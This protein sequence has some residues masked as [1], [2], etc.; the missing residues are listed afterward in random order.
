MKIKTILASEIAALDSDVLTGGGTD[1][2][3]A[4][5]KALDEALACGGVKLIM[6]GAALV[7][8]LKVHSNTTIE[9][10]SP[11]CG[12]YL[13]D[14][15]NC[16]IVTNANWQPYSLDTRNIALI[17]GTY[18]Q[19]CLH[20]EHDVP[21][22]PETRLHNVPE[23]MN[24][25]WIYC[26]EFYGVE[27][28]TLRDLTIRNQR[29]FAFMLCC[30]RRCTIENVWI[31]LIDYM[32]ANNQDGFHF[33]GPGEFLTIRNVGG[34]VGDDFMNLGP[35]EHDG[36]SSITDVIVDGVY[37]D[38]ADQ[39]IRLLSRGTGKLDRVT[40]RN[41][42]GCY[43]GLGFY[44]NPWSPTPSYGDFGNIRFENIDLRPLD[45]HYINDPFLFAVG[46]NIERLTFQNIHHHRA[47][48]KYNLFQI[49]RT[50]YSAEFNEEHMLEPHIGTLIVDSLTV[51]DDDQNA[52][53][54]E[55]MYLK[56]RV[57]TLILRDITVLRTPEI[58]PCGTFLRTYPGSRLTNLL[59]DRTYTQKLA[60]FTDFAENTVQ[61]TT[62]TDI[63]ET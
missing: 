33:W 51:D 6:D 36:K 23:D 63:H 60:H 40:I 31:D 61:N 54:T 12:F 59:V 42:S 55:Y 53:D 19:N 39:A 57:D 10:M 11:D 49:G 5:Q 34:R 52:A 7:R 58:E 32:P 21:R 30:F 13:A 24:N 14:N 4:L 25:H 28:L 2:T 37:L 16:A 62:F 29:T 44:I 46:G 18:N 22:T 8:G 26:I 41:V 3:E 43:H 15:S 1:D 27:N 48:H 20:Q 35:D 47:K 17:G 38:D 45:V 9:C 56:A 50:T